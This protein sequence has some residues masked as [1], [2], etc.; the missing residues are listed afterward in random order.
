VQPEKAGCER[1]RC[2]GNQKNVKAN[3]LR[4]L[5]PSILDQKRHDYVTPIID[6]AAMLHENPVGN[7]GLW[8][9]RRPHGLRHEQ[10]TE[11]KRP[12]RIQ[13]AHA[14]KTDASDHDKRREIISIRTK[15][16]AVQTEETYQ[17]ETTSD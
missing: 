6:R 1:V 13:N 10:T 12:D 9:N 14:Q 16:D 3:L 11:P 7:S 5:H 8:S 2:A 4:R 15:N 17:H